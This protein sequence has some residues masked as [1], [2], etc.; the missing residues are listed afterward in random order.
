MIGLE[1]LASIP[2]KIESNAR[3]LRDGAAHC[4]PMI[5]ASIDQ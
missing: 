1:P 4:C 3:A 2:G 5:I